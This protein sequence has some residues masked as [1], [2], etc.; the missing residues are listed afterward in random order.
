MLFT[1]FEMKQFKVGENNRL[2]MGRANQTTKN[3]F[4]KNLSFPKFFE[5]NTSYF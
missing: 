5:I 3:K 1:N 2:L 4:S